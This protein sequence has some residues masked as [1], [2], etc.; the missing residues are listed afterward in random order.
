MILLG[1][2]G[3]D[4]EVRHLD[5]GNAVASLSLAT[6]ET[7]ND[8]KTGEK[9]TVTEWHRVVAWGK[10]AEI[11]EKH[12]SKGAKIYCEG[13]LKTRDY[14]QD[15]VKKYVTEVVIDRL[16][17]LDGRQENN[18]TQPEVQ[19]QPQGEENDDLPF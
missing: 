16:Q 11:I 2:L 7:Y 18:K 17:M 13:K 1:N 10:L 9:K 19:P 4:P 5:G 8:K 3:K 15:G 12:L 14:D 6:S